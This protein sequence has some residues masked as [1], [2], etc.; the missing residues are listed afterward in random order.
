MLVV[1]KNEKILFT[2]KFKCSFIKG[3]PDDWLPENLA[4]LLTLCGDSITLKL[5]GSKAINGRMADIASIITSLCLV[6][7]QLGY[8]SRKL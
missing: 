8:L 3:L 5:I 4:Q 2:D 1:L 7:T 6:S